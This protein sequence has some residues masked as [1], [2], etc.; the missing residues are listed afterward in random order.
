MTPAYSRSDSLCLSNVAD[1]RGTPRWISLKR[2]LPAKSS[3]IMSNVHF[4]VRTSDAN[5]T[6]QNCPYSL[7]IGGDLPA[8]KFSEDMLDRKPADVWSRKLTRFLAVCGSCCPP[9]TPWSLPSL[10]GV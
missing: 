9:W 3:R 5:A 10:Q 6:G 4:G 7:S 1:R 2:V 8:P